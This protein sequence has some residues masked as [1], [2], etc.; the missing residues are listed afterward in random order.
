MKYNKYTTKSSN[1]TKLLRSQKIW[2]DLVCSNL[3]IDLARAV[4]QH[5]VNSKVSEKLNNECC[6]TLLT[7]DIPTSIN[8]KKEAAPILGAHRTFNWFANLPKVMS[9]IVYGCGTDFR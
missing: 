5:I 2:V 3:N 4:K 8:Q 7:N 1:I 9:R 6:M